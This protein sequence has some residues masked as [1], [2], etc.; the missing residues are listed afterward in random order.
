MCVYYVDINLLTHSYCADSPSSWAINTSL[1]KSLNSRM[2][3]WFKVRLKL[4]VLKMFRVG[5]GSCYT[6]FNHIYPR[7]DIKKVPESGI[8]AQNLRKKVLKTSEIMCLIN[9]NNNKGKLTLKQD[10]TQSN[11]FY[12]CKNQLLAAVYLLHRHVAD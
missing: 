8:K 10:L 2:K 7:T 12:L 11:L 9:N 5:L 1:H 4:R 6:M 3:T